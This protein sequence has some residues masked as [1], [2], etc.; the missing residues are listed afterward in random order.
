M[1][2]DCSTLHVF[3]DDPQAADRRYSVYNDDTAR[4]PK[5]WIMMVD[6]GQLCHPRGST[7]QALYVGQIPN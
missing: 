4:P 7:D 3:C 1:P 5:Q 2:G 6:F